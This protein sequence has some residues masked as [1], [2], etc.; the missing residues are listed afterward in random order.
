V[1]DRCVIHKLACSKLGL[2]DLW[3]SETC[4]GITLLPNHRQAS[5]AHSHRASR[6]KVVERVMLEPE[7][8]AAYHKD[9]HLVRPIPHYSL[10]NWEAF[11]ADWHWTAM[12]L[13]CVKAAVE[14]KAAGN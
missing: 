7:I 9:R 10:A 2:G 4:Y 8:R 3:E 12:G 13:I 14:V 1:L 5:V 11:V 6:H